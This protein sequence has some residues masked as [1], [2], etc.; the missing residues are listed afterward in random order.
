[1]TIVLHAMLQASY[2]SYKWYCVVGF[3]IE[4]L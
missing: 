4:G 2:I 1:M 3:C